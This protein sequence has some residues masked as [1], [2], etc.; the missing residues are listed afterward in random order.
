MALNMRG[1]RPALAL[2][3]QSWASWRSLCLGLLLVVLGS[4]GWAQK[5]LPPVPAL[6]AQLMDQTGTLSPA[7]RQQ[8]TA[9]LE[10]IER[11]YGSQVVVLMVNSTAPEDIAAYANRVASSWKIGRKDAGDGLLFIIAKNDRSLRLEVARGLE[12]TIP[13]IVAG[14]II[15]NIV[16][17]QLRSGDFA[18]A[19][20]AGL[21]AIEARLAGDESLPAPAP[22]A[23]ATPDNSGWSSTLDN[24]F[25][26]LF[27][28]VP[29]VCSLLA[30][31]IGRPLTMLLIGSG[32]GVGTFFTT[33]SW[34][35][36]LVFAAVAAFI[37]LCASGGGGISSGG[38]GRSGRSG[39]WS[40]GSSSGRSSGGG[41]RS[42][43]GGSFGGG[44][45]SGKW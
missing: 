4:L 42:G 36:A 12:G 17:P 33:G 38:S 28:A 26:I 39:G 14:R 41:F 24:L 43:G 31:A 10:A 35:Q 40:S 44:G 18:A 27:F 15:Q 2:T 8:I 34:L 5:G 45:A 16:V 13:D 21:T 29:V 32:V 1:Q 30:R 7:Q 23:P 20:E 11:Q 19:I 22:V 25:P 9:K 37:A 6:T 3:G